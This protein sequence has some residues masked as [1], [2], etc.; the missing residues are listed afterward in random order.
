[1]SVDVLT[2]NP[3]FSPCHTRPVP[4]PPSPVLSLQSP[5]HHLPLVP[6]PA[7]SHPLPGVQPL[8]M[9][10]HQDR[11][12]AAAAHHAGPLPLQHARIPGQEDAGR[13]RG[14]AWTRLKGSVRHLQEVREQVTRNQLSTSSLHL[15]VSNPAPP[16][17]TPDPQC[18]VICHRE[19]LAWF[20]LFFFL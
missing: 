17:L 10:D 12:G 16:S 4:P 18:A 3:F 13:L 2:A 11:A 8:Q 6:E 20:I 1:M 15:A 5:R 9:A 14:G 19:T 7:E